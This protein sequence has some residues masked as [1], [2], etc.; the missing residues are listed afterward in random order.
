MITIPQVVSEEI[1]KRP[2]YISG[3][4]QGVLNLSAVAR[5]LQP[6][7]ER[8]LRKEVSHNA[9]LL[10]LQ[11]LQRTSLRSAK[12]ERSANRGVYS[13]SISSEV[14]VISVKSNNRLNAALSSSIANLPEKYS[15]AFLH[16]D[17]GDNKVLVVEKRYEDAVRR[18][19]KTAGFK[20]A[21]VVYSD[22]LVS[23]KAPSQDISQSSSYI[24]RML[25]WHG[26][27]FNRISLGADTINLVLNRKDAHRISEIL[28]GS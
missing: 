17:D 5:D 23:I 13:V 28:D 24:I 25:Q 20:A 27:D 7:V 6:V 12:K 2:M 10:A 18:A 19:M 26:I 15:G 1:K 22:A 16:V 8:V 21:D 3:M 4:Q 9:V 14:V 11:R